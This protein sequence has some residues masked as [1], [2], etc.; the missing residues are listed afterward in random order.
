MWLTIVLF[1]ISLLVVLP[2]PV[3]FL[4][5]VRIF[6][7]EWSYVLAIIALLFAVFSSWRTVKG[8]VKGMI[9]IVSFVL[10]A[11]PFIQALPVSDTVQSE[12]EA[13]WGNSSEES[14]V[15]DSPSL[16]KLFPSSGAYE[17]FIY[18]TVDN[19]D[20]TL[21]F[22]Q[23]LERRKTVPCV[24]VIH[25]GMWD[26]GSSG[27]LSPL[28]G[29]LADNG[30]AVAAINY[31]LAPRWKYPAPV[32]DVRAAITFLQNH[33][34]S[35]GIAPNKFVLLGRGSGGQI[36]LMAAYTLNES[37]VRGVISFYAP[38]DLEYAGA[39]P[40]NSLSPDLEKDI[41]QYVGGSYAVS[42]DLYR[43]ASP[44]E[45]V[46]SLCIPT[47]IIHGEQDEIVPYEH[48]VRLDR[49][50]SE[51]Q[52]K[53]QLVALPWATHNCDLNFNGLSGQIST[54]AVVR[55]LASVTK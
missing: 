45:A 53:H 52:V 37:A 29:Y 4:W 26:G 34:D 16:M 1:L 3:F 8:R 11:L 49:K 48:S 13:I 18:S 55:F 2:A 46:S 33:A 42:P 7:T 19:T 47:L 38:A 24:V 50:L 39:H 14:G 32:E 21:R 5:Y 36:A 35:L 41:A 22:Y 12:G 27:E 15:L 43:N 28:N 51:A 17:M 30:Y 44:L 54:N 10:A 31:R 6:A 20:L 9:N 25:G 40:E 23:S